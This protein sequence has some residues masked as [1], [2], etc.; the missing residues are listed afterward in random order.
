RDIAAVAVQALT[1]SGHESKVYELTGPDALSYADVAA[2]VS[3]ATG[4]EIK[5]VPIGDADIKAAL[6]GQGAPE[7]YADAFVDLQR[8]YR[9]GTAAQVSNDVKNVTGRDPIAFDQYARD[10]ASA[11]A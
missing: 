8:F 6:V 1:G 2:K 4:R 3:A 10:H 5:Y 7:P 11:F 9:G